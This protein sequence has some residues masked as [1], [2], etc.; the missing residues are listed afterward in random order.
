M[1]HVSAF[2]R[3]KPINK[4][5]SVYNEYKPNDGIIIEF[6]NPD[7]RLKVLLTREMAYDLAMRLSDVE[8]SWRFHENLV[9][10]MSNMSS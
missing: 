4:Y 7:S 10:N 9:N 3:L 8:F 2:K 6:E 1:K 5:T